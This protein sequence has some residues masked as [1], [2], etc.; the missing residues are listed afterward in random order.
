MIETDTK[1]LADTIVQL[2]SSDISAVIC[3]IAMGKVGFL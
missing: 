2:F 3:F 1:V